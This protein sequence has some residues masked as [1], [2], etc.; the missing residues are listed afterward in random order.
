MKLIHEMKNMLNLR[1]LWLKNREVK[2]S[3]FR[4]A[5]IILFSKEYSVEM[6]EFF[7]L[8]IIAWVSV[9][10]YVRISVEIT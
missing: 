9:A 8:N 1:N 5:S 7:Y 6:T 3:Y 10:N 2:F 4:W